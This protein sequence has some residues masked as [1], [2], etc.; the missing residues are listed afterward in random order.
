[1]G[2]FHQVSIVDIYNLLFAGKSIQLNFVN[3]EDAESFRIRLQQFKTRQDR[4]QVAIGMLSDTDKQKLSFRFDKTSC[5]AHIKF[6]D[7]PDP[8]QYTIKIIE[9]DDKSTEDTDA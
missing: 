3:Y 5:I 9:N 1:M 4:A 8:R 2:E 7:R 6:V